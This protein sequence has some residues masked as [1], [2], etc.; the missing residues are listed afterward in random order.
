MMG[1]ISFVHFVA[2]FIF[3]ALEFA[4]VTNFQQDPKCSLALKMIRSILC[5]SS[6]L[7]GRGGGWGVPSFQN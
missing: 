5:M 6:N 1:E 3:S 2:E 4:T 7:N